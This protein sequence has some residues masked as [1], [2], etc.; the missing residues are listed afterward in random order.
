MAST[1]S[2]Y[3]NKI[4]IDYPQAGV[5]NDSQGFRD[6]FKN[7]YNAFSATDVAIKDLEVNAVN[8]SDLNDFGYTGIVKK[9]ILQSEAKKVRDLSTSPT[10]GNIYLDYTE[11]NYQKFSLSS[12]TTTFIVQ[13]WPDSGYKAEMELSVTPNSTSTTSITFGGGPYTAVGNL[14]LPYVSTTTV[15]R[16]FV[17]W[18][19]DGGAATYVMLKGA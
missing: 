5:D 15:T 12:G 2:I 16:H 9:V 7:I 11:A 18:T 14:S 4:R 17:V 10:N 3:F 19:D 1:A 13:N 6:N 8:L